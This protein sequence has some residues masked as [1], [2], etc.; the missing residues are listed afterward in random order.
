MSQAH[1]LTVRRLVLAPSALLLAG[2]CSGGNPE[3]RAACGFSALAG[4]TMVLE[5]MRAGSKA[6]TEPPPGLSGTVPARVV[7]RGTT[8]ALAAATDSGILIGY[9][10]EGFPTQ[11]GFGLALVEDSA[12]TFKGVLIYDIEPPR[13]VPQLGTV[14][15]GSTLIPLFGTRVTWAS[16]SSERCP[17]FGTVEPATQP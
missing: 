10:G 16:V 1:K 17:L 6:L 15:S 8:A 14:A 2:A 9:T 3:N 12:E 7:G 4:A 11:P 13:G 5:Q